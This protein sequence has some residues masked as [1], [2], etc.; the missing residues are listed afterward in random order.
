VIY[1]H[2]PPMQRIYQP[3]TIVDAYSSPSHVCD[4]R[5]TVALCVGGVTCQLFGKMGAAEQEPSGDGRFCRHSILYYPTTSM[6]T[7]LRVL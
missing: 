1:S 5:S 3:A 4:W 6:R 7:I 2:N